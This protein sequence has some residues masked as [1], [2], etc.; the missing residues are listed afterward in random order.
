MHKTRIAV[1]TGGFTA[2]ANI[3]VKSASTVM[4]HLDALRFERYLIIIEKSGWNLKADDGKLY[5][6]DRND[7]SVMINGSRLTFDIAFIALHGSPAEDGKLQGYFDMIGMRYTGSGVLPLALSFDKAATKKYLQNSGLHM[8]Q[9]LMFNFKNPILSILDIVNEKLSYPVFVK[10][11]KNG[12][13]YGVSKVNK[14]E[15]LQEAIENGFKYDDELI[16]E[17]F[18]TGRELTCGVYNL[19]GNLRALPPTEIKSQNEF[20][21]YKAKYSGESNEITPAEIS[22]ELTHK[23]QAESIKVFT[24]LGLKGFARMDFILH[25]DDFYFLEANTVPG[26]TDESLIPQQARA[27]GWEL[28]DFFTAVVEESLK[29]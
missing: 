8:A 11:N 25:G 2:E 6:V 28:S 9:S 10:P 20:F 23:L 19:R 13:S 26:L 3:S 15:D 22:S 18:I 5:T 4:N 12:S 24:E 14:R 21:D 29:A 7:F 1:V 16:I 27:A 17:E